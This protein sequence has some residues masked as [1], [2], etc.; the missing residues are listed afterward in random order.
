MRL[1]PFRA[2]RPTPAVAAAVA[3]PPYDVVSRAEAAALA[4]GNPLSFL[5]VVRS[6][7]DLPD[8]VL[9]HDPRVYVKAR[10]NLDRLVRDGTLVREREPALCLYRLTMDGRAQVGVVGCVHVDDYEHGVIKKHET[11]RP[12]KEDDRVRHMLALDAHPEPVLLA[13]G[14]SQ[15]IARLQAQAISR[16]PIYDFTGAGGVRH[17]VWTLG[18]PA[19]YVESFDRVQGAYV[20]DG[21]HRS[22][23]A[24]RAAR[25]RARKGSSLQAHDERNWFPAVLFPAEE[26]R[27][28]PYNRVVADLVGQTPADVVRKLEAVGRLSTAATPSPS[29]PGSF[30]VYVRRRW[31]LLELDES[32]I[33][34]QDLLRSLDV[35]LLHDRVLAPILGIGDPRTDPRLDFVGGLRGTA[36]LEKR[37]DAGEAALA[38]SLHPTSIEQLIAVSDAGHVM[39]PKSTWFEPK[40]ASGLFV[41]PFS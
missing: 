1:H 40:L 19:P 37:V 29:R 24:W 31:Y 16:P 28:L 5:H 12:D 6:E 30:C 32:T 39:P 10:E 3:S 8:D 9:P 27:I 35:T 20:A 17:T 41:H 38:V 23:S 14:A 25:A 7:I 26:L 2:L 4:K 22:A 21:H 13:Y 18:D 36:E 15:A 33:D 11:T 34:R